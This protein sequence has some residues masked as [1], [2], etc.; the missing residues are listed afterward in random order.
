[1]FKK[2]LLNRDTWRRLIPV[3]GIALF[4]LIGAPWHVLATLANPPYFDL[5]MHSESGSYHGFFWF[6]FINEH[7]LRFLNLRYPRDYNTVSRPLF[8]L[9]HLVWFFPWSVYFLRLRKL[10]FRGDD[11]AA[12]MRLLAVC[13][14]GFIM[15]FFTFSTTQE[16][17]SLSAYPAIALLLGSVMADPAFRFE[18]GAKVAASIA[19]VAGVVIAFLLWNVRHLD[20]PGDIAR[21]LSE[22]PELYTLSL[23]HMADLT[24]QAFAYLK[25]PL[26]IALAATLIPARGAMRLDPIAALRYE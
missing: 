2:Q 19:G 8:W 15:V 26:G 7:V 1:M 4:L 11:R 25:L 12:R 16:Y 24:F 22:N 23:G 14:A 6:Y 3:Q 5:T 13:W 21:A 18:R 9:F 17:Y 20:A 10:N